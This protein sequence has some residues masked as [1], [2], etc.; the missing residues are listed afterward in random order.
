MKSSKFEMLS[1]NSRISTTIS[2][3]LPTKLCVVALISPMSETVRVMVS[4]VD[5]MSSACSNMLANMSSMCF[6]FICWLAPPML[7]CEGMVLN[8]SGSPWGRVMACTLPTPGTLNTALA[9]LSITRKSAELRSSRSVSMSSSS[10]FIFEAE[11]CRSAAAK[12]SCA[13]RSCC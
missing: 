8:S 5:C 12:P 2:L 7:I 13:G 4:M 11:K 10:G 9:I 6:W 3:V 1:R